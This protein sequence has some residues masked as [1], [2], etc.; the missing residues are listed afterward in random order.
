MDNI[1]E[2]KVKTSFECGIFVWE[3]STLWL[4]VGTVVWFSVITTD[5]HFNY[6][7]RV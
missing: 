7:N 4:A 5:I 6:I 2:Q 1:W 3:V